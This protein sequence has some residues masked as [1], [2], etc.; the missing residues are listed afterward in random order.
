MIKYIDKIKSKV[1]MCNESGCWNFQGWD[2]GKGYK[3]ISVN[4]I[5]QYVHRV[6]FEYYH[7]PLK[8][9]QEVEHICNN[10]SCCNP[11]HLKQGTRLTN[12]REMNKRRW[13]K[14]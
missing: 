14:V 7:K 13:A 8:Y 4:G 9:K 12:M 5:A 1:I 10:R 6:M 3:K 2:D 11:S